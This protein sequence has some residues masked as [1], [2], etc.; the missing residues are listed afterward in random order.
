MNLDDDFGASDL[1]ACRIVDDFFSQLVCS[2]QNLPGLA[3]E[4]AAVYPLSDLVTALEHMSHKEHYAIC[5]E[6]PAWYSALA[7]E[8]L[9]LAQMLTEDIASVGEL[10]LAADWI[11]TAPRRLMNLYSGR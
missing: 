9:V 1:I 11:I 6:D 5:R 10:R 4:Y 7:S 8:L 3:K 2:A